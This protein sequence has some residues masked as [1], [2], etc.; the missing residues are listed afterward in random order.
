MRPI[1]LTCFRCRD[2]GFIVAT[3]K[4]QNGLF[5]F[6]CGCGVSIR[7]GLSDSI[8]VWSSRHAPDFVPDEDSGLG[9]VLRAPS[10]VS[11]IKPIITPKADFRAVVANQG[12]DDFDDEVPF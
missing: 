10:P 11:P 8:P 1:N 3:H 4:N 12:K 6:K 2:S 9:G 5:A 7:K